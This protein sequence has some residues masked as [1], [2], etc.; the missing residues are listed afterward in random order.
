MCVGLCAWTGPWT[1]VR[2]NPVLGPGPICGHWTGELNP[3]V[4]P[5]RRVL[6]P[7]AARPEWPCA[8]PRRT[9]DTRNSADAMCRAV[10]YS[11]GYLISE[12]ACARGEFCGVVAPKSVDRTE[13]RRSERIHEHV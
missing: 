3:S 8:A 1:M 2:G 13:V 7:A 9:E 12:F 10:L 5:L 11:H 6:L 4:R